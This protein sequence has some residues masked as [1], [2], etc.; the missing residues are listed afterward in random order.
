MTWLYYLLKS[1]QN[2]AFGPSQIRNINEIFVE[3]S[4][5]VC[6]LPSIAMTLCLLSNQLKDIWM[7]QVI[8][9]DGTA[10]IN[11]LKWLSRYTYSETKDWTELSL[12]CR[13]TLDVIGISGF[14]YRFNALTEDSGQSSELGDAF[15][16][17]FGNPELIRPWR[18]LQGM[19]PALRVLVSIHRLSNSQSTDYHL[20]FQK[21]PGV[22][23]CSSNYGS[24]WPRITSK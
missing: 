1:S 2:P 18:V 24:N 11:V 15:N 16:V 10:R 22:R 12:S 4:V 19:I 21:N 3:K 17:V 7:S 14:N 23:E 13:M 8:A 6:I 9:G 5:Q 20:A